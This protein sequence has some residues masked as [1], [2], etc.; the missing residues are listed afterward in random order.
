MQD[1]VR[2]AQRRFHISKYVAYD[3]DIEY[4]VVVATR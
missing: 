1:A 2:D 3:N 4:V